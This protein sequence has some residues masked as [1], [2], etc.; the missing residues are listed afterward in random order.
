MRAC[1]YLPLQ[2]P[3]GLGEEDDSEKLPESKEKGGEEHSQRIS[4]RA[5]SGPLRIVPW[6]FLQTTT[7][8]TTPMSLNS[9]GE[10]CLGKGDLGDLVPGAQEGLLGEQG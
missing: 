2:L 7:H 1:I 3:S 8:Q 4:R 5:L 6:V 10:F 9:F